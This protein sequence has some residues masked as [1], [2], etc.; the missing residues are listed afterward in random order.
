M[1]VNLQLQEL[2]YIA[3][4]GDHI[5]AIVL[6]QHVPVDVNKD[7]WLVSGG[8]PI[9]AYFWPDIIE[10]VQGNLA[11]SIRKK[12]AAKRLQERVHKLLQLESDDEEALQLDCDDKKALHLESD[13]KNALQLESDDKKALKNALCNALR[14]FAHHYFSPTSIMLEQMRYM[15]ETERKCRLITKSQHL[16]SATI[17][18]DPTSEDWF[19]V[20][21]QKLVEL[22]DGFDH[23]VRDIFKAYRAACSAHEVSC[24]QL[25][26]M[27]RLQPHVLWKICQAFIDGLPRQVNE[28]RVRETVHSAIEQL[29]QQQPEYLALQITNVLIKIRTQHFDEVDLS[30]VERSAIAPGRILQSRFSPAARDPARTPPRVLE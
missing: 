19:Q 21:E 27:S 18:P 25:A 29:L 28:V 10:A 4:V 8:Y 14:G 3:D 11:S 30:S 6:H 24:S 20:L 23:D 12:A 22:G 1:P 13:N 7:S 17:E 5:A 26:Q 9:I 16:T 2:K 15:K